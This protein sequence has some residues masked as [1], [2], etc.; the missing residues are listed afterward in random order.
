L[1]KTEGKKISLVT[2]QRSVLDHHKGVI[3]DPADLETVTKLYARTLLIAGPTSELPTM[4]PEQST[5]NTNQWL[6]DE[7]I[8]LFSSV[9]NSAPEE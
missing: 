4:R 3:A 8:A 9:E 5:R 2:R 1:E 7:R 6:L